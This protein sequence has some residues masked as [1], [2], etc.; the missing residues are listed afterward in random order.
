MEVWNGI[1]EIRL[2]E[3]TEKK[4]F[5]VKIKYKNKLII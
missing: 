3:L 1:L 2:T 5:S 4:M